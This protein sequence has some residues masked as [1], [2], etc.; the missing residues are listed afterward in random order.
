[1][2]TIKKYSNSILKTDLLLKNIN[3]NVLE[4]P[5]LSK[6]V[7]SSGVKDANSNSNKILVPLLIL[8]LI[9]G[10]N[11]FYT[12][13][14]KSIANFKLRKGKIIG[15]KV[16]LRKNNMN[17]FF[18]KFVHVI[19]PQLSELK[20]LKYKNS[21]GKNSITIGIEDCSVFPELENQFELINKIYGV[22]ISIFLKNRN[23]NKDNLFFSGL[24]IPFK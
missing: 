4:A 12:K 2:K 18:E 17:K 3:K 1:M 5:I 15:C 11:P 22:N 10:Q 24:K 21:K 20:D 9:T 19:L 16:T 14:K 23:L 7:I 8:N 6:I 13:A